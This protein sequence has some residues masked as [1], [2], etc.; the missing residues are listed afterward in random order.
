MYFCTARGIGAPGPLGRDHIPATAHSRSMVKSGLMS[1]SHQTGKRGGSAVGP[2]RRRK[3]AEELTVAKRYTSIPASVV[4]EIRKASKM[5]GSQGRALQVA[6]EILI[7]MRKRPLLPP[8]S[9]S[10]ITQMTYKLVPRTVEL[11]D[12][13]ADTVYENRQQVFF[14]CVE[15]L[16]MTDI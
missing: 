1:D 16:K 4:K 5:Y 7:R 8:E 6:T 3:S 9:N 11:I 15:A 14:A 12:E 13:L 10:V 2:P